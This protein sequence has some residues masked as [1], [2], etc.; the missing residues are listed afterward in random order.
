MHKAW[1]E[2]NLAQREDLDYK[3]WYQDS[4]KLKKFDSYRREN[5]DKR[6]KL[7]AA[8]W[9]ANEKQLMKYQEWREKSWEHRRDIEYSD[10]STNSTRVNKFCA[11]RTTK[12]KENERKDVSYDTWDEVIRVNFENWKKQGDRMRD[13]LD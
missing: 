4:D 3:L 6:K 5:W 7:R 2:E 9:F 11:W 8:D 13:D 10:Y 1:Q 12:G